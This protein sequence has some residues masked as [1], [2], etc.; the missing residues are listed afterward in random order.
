LKR[1]IVIALLVITLMLTLV[2]PVAAA[3]PNENASHVAQCAITMGGQHVAECARTM[4]RGVSQCAQM[5]G[6]CPHAM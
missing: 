5:S 4:D 2:T 3:G 1:I 6:P